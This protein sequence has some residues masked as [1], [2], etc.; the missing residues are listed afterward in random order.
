MAPRQRGSASLSFLQLPKVLLYTKLQSNFLYDLRHIPSLGLLGVLGSVVLSSLFYWPFSQGP[1]DS[2]REEPE[3]CP[4][5]SA[6]RPSQHPVQT[7][8]SGPMYPCL[9]YG[10][11]AY[12]GSQKVGTWRSSNIHVPTSWSLAHVHPQYDLTFNY[13]NSSCSHVPT[14]WRLLSTLHVFT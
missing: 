12:S 2:L 11:K 3:S 8:S 1:P 4:G 13:K 7:D 10:I 9:R 5:T 6:N 14:C